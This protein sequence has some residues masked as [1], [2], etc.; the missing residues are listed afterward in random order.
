MR[1]EKG[2]AARPVMNIG[3]IIACQSSYLGSV[4]ENVSRLTRTCWQVG[5]RS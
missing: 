3:T 5:M 1:L 2:R 4:G